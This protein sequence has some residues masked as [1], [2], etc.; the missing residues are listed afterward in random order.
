MIEILKSV[1]LSKGSKIAISVWFILLML[2]VINLLA[3]RFMSK[4]RIDYA[5]MI[6]ESEITRTIEKCKAVCSEMAFINVKNAEFVNTCQKQCE[7]NRNETHTYEIKLDFKSKIF[8]AHL[9][10]GAII[11]NEVEWSKDIE[12]LGGRGFN[13]SVIKR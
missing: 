5:D 1:R 4:D 6:V 11:L 8:R 7:E 12:R 3:L 9:T 10:Y 2:V 13:L